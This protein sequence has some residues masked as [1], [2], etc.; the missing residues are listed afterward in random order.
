[1]RN[2]IKFLLATVVVVGIFV[3]G[4][5]L[6]PGTQEAAPVVGDEVPAVDRRCATC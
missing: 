5:R 2:E 6:W 3:L 4:W 1:M